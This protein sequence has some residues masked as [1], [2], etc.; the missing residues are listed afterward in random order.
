MSYSIKNRKKSKVLH[1]V[2]SFT[3]LVLLLML[4]T[5]LSALAKITIGH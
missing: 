3:M 2:S 5:V 1:T 4:V